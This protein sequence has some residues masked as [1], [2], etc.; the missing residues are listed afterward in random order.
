MIRSSVTLLG[1]SWQWIILARA[2]SQTVIASPRDN[3]GGC[4]GVYIGVPGQPQSLR[5]RRVAAHGRTAEPP[6]Q[7]ARRQPRDQ[8][9]GGHP[10][11][12]MT[13]IRRNVAEWDEHKAALVQAGMRQ[14]EGR[15]RALPAVIIEQVEIEAAGG[16]PGTAR[17]RETRFEREH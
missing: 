16:V 15:C 14:D 12:R 3:V 13:S 7:L 8:L 6:N 17:A 11:R 5:P 4:G 10:Q 9:G 2:V 1:R